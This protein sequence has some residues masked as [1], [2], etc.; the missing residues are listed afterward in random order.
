MDDGLDDDTED[1][2]DGEADKKVADGDVKAVLH[3]AHNAVVEIEGVLS[4]AT[5]MS[6]M[7]V[8]TGCAG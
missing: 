8:G 7:A 4:T 6:G 2:V 1:T 3:A 5:T